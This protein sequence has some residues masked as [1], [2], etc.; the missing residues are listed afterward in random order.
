M[1]EIKVPRIVHNRKFKAQHKAQY[2]EAKSMLN[3]ELYR[4]IA[5]MKEYEEIQKAASEGD[6]G[7]KSLL[8]ILG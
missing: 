1:R 3:V 2:N 6:V 7:A 4:T 5:L 8:Y